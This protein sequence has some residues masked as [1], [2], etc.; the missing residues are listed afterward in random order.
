MCRARILKAVVGIAMAVVL[1][2]CGDEMFNA[3]CDLVVVNDSA[4][5]LQ[6]FVNGREAFAIRSST[7][8]TLNDIGPGRHVLEALDYR[9]NLV[10]RRTIELAPGED[11]FWILDDC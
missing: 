10:R 5:D 3:E 7:D 1:A 8:R 4:C 9:G 6:I 2:G 11:F